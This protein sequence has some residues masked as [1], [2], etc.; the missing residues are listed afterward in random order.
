VIVGLHRFL[1]PS[2]PKTLK[3]GGLAQS[4]LARPAKDESE[5]RIQ[6]LLVETYAKRT[7]G[8]LQEALKLCQQALE[9][10]EN[11]SEIYLALGGIFEACH[12]FEEALVAYAH[13]IRIGTMPTSTYNVKAEALERKGRIFYEQHRYTEALRAI[14]QS[15]KL[16]PRRASLH[17][18]KYNVLS[19]LNRSGEAQCALRDYMNYR[20]GLS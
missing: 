16:D 7:G 18:L 8:A 12:R 1:V 13:A 9:L 17:R 11:H 6:K 10:D 15:F 2:L 14:N 3:T 19:K 20:M 4:S 5:A